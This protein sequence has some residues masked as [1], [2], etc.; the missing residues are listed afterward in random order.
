MPIVIKSLLLSTTLACF[1]G[2]PKALCSAV[3]TFKEKEFL[4][5]STETRK[6]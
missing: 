6:Y 1:S 4:E 2:L 5:A 3:N